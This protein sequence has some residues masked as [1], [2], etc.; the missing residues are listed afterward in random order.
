M[1]EQTAGQEELPR[2]TYLDHTLRRARTAAEQRSHRFVT[3]EHLLLALLDD[4][5]AGKLLQITGADV[6]VIHSTVADAVNNRMTSLVAPDGQQPSFSYR[7]DWLFQCANEDARG[8]GRLEVDGA[9]VL[10][11]IAKDAESNASGILAAN[12]F[13]PRAALALM[14]RPL[15]TQRAPQTAPMPARSVP[16]PEVAARNPKGDQKP[17]NGD[18]SK[19]PGLPLA[20][21]LTEGGESM[22]A[23]VASVRTILE[24]EEI[25]ERAHSQR[26][27][28]APRS[29]PHA[30]G[31]G[32]AMRPAEAAGEA[33]ARPEPR[34]GPSQPAKRPLHDAARLNGFAE[35]AAPAF[36]LEKPP[37]PEKRVAP[38]RAAARGKAG[39]VALL[40]K[41]LENVP[42]K[43]R[44]ATPQKFQISMSKEEAGLLLCRHTRQSPQHM[45]GTEPA[46]RAITVRLTAPQGAFTLE[47]LTPETQW[48]LNRS[49]SE[50]FGTWAWTA[51]PGASGLHYLKASI[52]TREVTPNGPGP[53]TAL[54]DQTIKVRVR[55]N[56]WLTF[57]R[58]VRAVFFLLA[59]SGL[60]MTVSYALKMAAKLH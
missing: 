21:K 7:F 16:K 25:K 31:N 18:F 3:L 50:A 8:M 19:G 56:V 1:N 49:A 60:T 55:G 13:N 34:I 59:G 38:P 57:G 41:I 35:G 32:A 10:I 27:A 14:K 24:A 37:K 36:D 9:L 17:S 45:T 54:P 44:V 40:A 11:A 58:F 12:G 53:E 30:K 20:A 26:V 39:N 22:E 52:S 4:P 29:E 48:L 43:A 46:C 6:A 23:M 28:P 42:R 5:D 33:A 51:V 2:T 15:P 47:A